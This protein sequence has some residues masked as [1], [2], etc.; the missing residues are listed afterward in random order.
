LSALWHFP[1]DF[2]VLGESS[3]TRESA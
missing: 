2:G 3:G 1:E